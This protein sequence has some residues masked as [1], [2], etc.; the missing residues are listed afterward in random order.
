MNWNNPKL[1]YELSR[2]DIL[3]LNILFNATYAMNIKV[4][5][6][7][8]LPNSHKLFMITAPAIDNS[9]Y[10]GTGFTIEEAVKSWFARVEEIKR[11]ESNSPDK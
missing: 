6:E 5:G 7:K 9:N 10:T 4:I 3:S 2:K 8:E 11:T 1:P